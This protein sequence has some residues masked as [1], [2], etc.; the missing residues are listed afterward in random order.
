MKSD[1][2]HESLE[3]MAAN[4]LQKIYDT[5]WVQMKTERLDESNGMVCNNGM[6]H[7]QFCKIKVEENL[8]GMKISNSKHN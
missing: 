3:I 1:M 8:F 6:A 2:I 4:R 7:L 5:M